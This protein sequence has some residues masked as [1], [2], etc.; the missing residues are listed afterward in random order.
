MEAGMVA[1]TFNPRFWETEASL[2]YISEFQDSQ[3]YIV[4][5]LKKKITT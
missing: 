2:V 1:R 5:S 4:R 3:G